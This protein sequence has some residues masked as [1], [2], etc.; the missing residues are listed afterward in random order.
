MPL[1]TYY[2]ES[3]GEYRD[4]FQSMNE[5]H[6][7]FGENGSEDDWRRVYHAPNMSIDSNIDPNNPR[8]FVNKTANKKGTMGDLLDRS[9]ELSE[10]RAS[11]LGTEDPIKRKFFDN[12]AKERNGKKHLNDVKPFEKNGFKVD[13]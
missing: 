7:Y 6:Q 4:V 5:E 13:Y 10:K 9:K 2:R 12:Y 1:Y 11:K 3:T 8:D